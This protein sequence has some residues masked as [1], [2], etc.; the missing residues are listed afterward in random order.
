MKYNPLNKI[1]KR[2]NKC[3]IRK[4][5]AEFCERKTATDGLEGWCTPCVVLSKKMRYLPQK[6]RKTC[7]ICWGPTT[8]E[9]GVCS[10]CGREA[11]LEF[12]SMIHNYSA[13]TRPKAE[14]LNHFEDAYAS[15]YSVES[16]LRFKRIVAAMRKVM[17]GE[18]TNTNAIDLN[19][20]HAVALGSE[21]QSQRG[22]EGARQVGDLIQLQHHQERAAV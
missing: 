11:L 15:A 10:R 17:Y 5:V 19:R 2:C 1:D 4:P 16:R 20:Q 13:S 14:Q 3:K 8:S 9:D 12:G 21:V 7:E 22:A 6:A 18:N